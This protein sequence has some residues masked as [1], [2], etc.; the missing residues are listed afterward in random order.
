MSPRQT[1][2]TLALYPSSFYGTKR[3]IEY[4]YIRLSHLQHFIEPSLVSYKMYPHM[5]KARKNIKYKEYTVD[6]SKRLA[7]IL[8][9]IFSQQQRKFVPRH[10]CGA[11]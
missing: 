10:V 11:T 4:R 2:Q 7:V 5:Q 1:W 9:Q 6:Q 8:V 3:G